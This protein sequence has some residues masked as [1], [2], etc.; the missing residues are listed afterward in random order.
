MKRNEGHADCAAEQ[1]LNRILEVAYKCVFEQADQIRIQHIQAGLR[2]DI[3]YVL[4]PYG[5]LS[6][7]VEEAME[8]SYDPVSYALVIPLDDVCNAIR[9]VFGIPRKE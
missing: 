9:S 7:P 8:V 4:A 6:Q 3:R 2:Q 5:V 1:I